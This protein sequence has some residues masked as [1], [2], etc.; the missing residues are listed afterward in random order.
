MYIIFSILTIMLVIFDLATKQLALRFLQ[1][2]ITVPLIKDVFHLTYCENTGAAFS[3]FSGKTMY[4]GIFSGIVIICLI[5]YI[6]IKKPKSKTLLTSLALLI[7]GGTGNMIDRIFRGYVVD[8]FDFRLINF[9]IFNLADIFVCVGVGLLC[10]YL[11]FIDGKTE[12]K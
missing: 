12:I 2:V 8:F 6:I 10:I 4:L 5:G 11:F 1:P 9:A 7:S 3:I